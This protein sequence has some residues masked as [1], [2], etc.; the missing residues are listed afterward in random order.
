[1]IL[2][3]L[4]LSLAQ[5]AQLSIVN[6][7]NANIRI[8]KV[9]SKCTEN[10]VVPSPTIMKPGSTYILNGLEPVVYIYKICGSGACIDTAIGMNDKIISYTLDVIPDIVTKINTKTIPDVWPGNLECKN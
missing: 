6:H 9:Q 2:L 4:V 5:A 3:N 1:M 10:L 8:L 7:T